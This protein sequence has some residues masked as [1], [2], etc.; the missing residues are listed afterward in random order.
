MLQIV[1][2]VELGV[3]WVVWALAFVKPQKR[4]ASAKK[5]E[6]APASRWGIF[7][8]MLG[9]ACIWAFVRPVGFEKSA[10][11]LIASMVLGPPSV[12]L[13]WMAA[14]HL[15]KQWRFEAALSEDHKLITTGPYRWLRNPI[16]ASMLGMLLATGFAKTWWP[17][18]VAG[19]IFF[20]IGTEI[21]VRAEERLLAARF[22]EEFA[23][24]KTTTPAYFPF[25]Q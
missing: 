11:S 22:G 4:A 20:V 14:R 7:F 18:L 5:A 24:Y 17:L 3:C 6:R 25:L 15:D 21:R 19:V 8:V 2:W 12:V 10:A 1:A 9:F 23:Q 13:V 16:Y